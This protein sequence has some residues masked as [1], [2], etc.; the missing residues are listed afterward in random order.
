MLIKS[1]CSRTV[2]NPFRKI[3]KIVKRVNQCKSSSFQ[4]PW[5]FSHGG[6]NHLSKSFCLNH[7]ELMSLSLTLSTCPDKKAQTIRDGTANAH[8]LSAQL[9]RQTLVTRPARRKRKHKA[10]VCMSSCPHS[11]LLPRR[12]TP[13][14][15][16]AW[17][18]SVKKVVPKKRSSQ[19][20][21]A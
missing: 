9:L 12:F 1:H 19:T 2:L 16:H 15:T 4:S 6:A 11:L 13:A 17:Q 7:V 20:K 10:A 21:Q 3:S 14:Q 8:P 5:T 18:L